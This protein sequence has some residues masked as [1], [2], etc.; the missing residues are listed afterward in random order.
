MSSLPSD[1]SADQRHYEG[2]YNLDLFVGEVADEFKCSICLCVMKDAHQLDGCQHMFCKVCIT[3]YLRTSPNTPFC[4]IDRRPATVANIVPAPRAITNLMARL[5]V[6]CHFHTEGCGVRVPLE[7]LEDHEAGCRYRTCLQD[8]SRVQPRLSSVPLG[9]TS[10]EPAITLQVILGDGTK[11]IL[12]S[13]LPSNTVIELKRK[14]Q[15]KEGSDPLQLTLNF[16]SKQLVDDK[17]L[18]EYNIQNQSII[19]ASRR[20]RGGFFH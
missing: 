19:Y 8:P 9:Q 3:N 6:K 17:R 13:A 12:I 1:R 10:D 2:L 14:I 4:P 5:E 20:F 11:Q 16:K 7:Q 18:S 15:A